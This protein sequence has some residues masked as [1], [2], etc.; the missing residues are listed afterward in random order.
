MTIPLKSFYVKPVSVIK[1][2][3]LR[4]K[5]NA[6]AARGITLNVTKGSDDDIL[7]EAI[8]NEIAAAANNVVIKADKQM[9]DS[10]TGTDEDRVFGVFG[11]PRAGVSGSQG[12]IVAKISATTFVATGA[13]LTDAQG[14]RYQVSTGGVLTLVGTPPGSVSIPVTSIDVGVGTNHA[15]GD[16]LTWVAPPPYCD[17]TVTCDI[18]GLTN[19]ADAQTDDVYRV[20]GLA[21][22]RNPPAGGNSAQIIAWAEAGSPAVESAW[23]YPG[24]DGPG[25]FSVAI[26]AKQA[27]S[28]TLGRLTR[29]IQAS[30]VQTVGTYIAAQIPE[31]ANLKT[32]SVADSVTDVSIGLT[33]PNAVTATSPG[34]GGGW[35][36]GTPWPALAGTATRV[37]VSAVSSPTTFTLTS[38]D[39]A[40]TPA[41]TGISDGVTKIAWFDP[42]SLT[43]KTSTVLSHSG[44]TGA[45]VVTI[46]PQNPFSGIA[47]GHYVGPAAQNI[48]AYLTAFLGACAELGPGEWTT[49]VSV[50]PRAA[51][52]PAPSLAWPNTLTAQQTKPVQ[53]A[54]P[55]V[56]DTKY[57]YRSQSSA[58]VPAD[59]N[60]AVNII[61]LQNFG[62]YKI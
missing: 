9:P 51:R 2:D 47:V 15:A 16:V 40:T 34:P 35:T 59:T 6:Y 48:G 4:T 45:I 39:A 3:F 23:V 55:E 62:I 61:V 54:G 19:G 21:R 29:V 41:A 12:S 24:L 31:Y 10:A 27:Y 33:L 32:Y 18:G 52:H 56:L 57:F 8:A 17:P 60:T 20:V 7:A 28:A 5:K 11:V 22:L 42:V 13:Q 44:S 53:D 1:A 43:M 30:T 46:D 38:N 36:D 37:S 25:T 26:A 49:N 58:P 50:L 14:F